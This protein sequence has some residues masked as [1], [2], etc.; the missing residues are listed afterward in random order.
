MA[1]VTNEPFGT[2][3]FIPECQ[4]ITIHFGTDTLAAQEEKKV[5]L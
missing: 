2:T 5:D 1:A 3:Q 4:R